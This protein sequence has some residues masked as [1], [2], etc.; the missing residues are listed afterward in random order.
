[1]RRVII[2]TMV[3]IL[4]F[5]CGVV[6]LNWYL[7]SDAGDTTVKMD[8]ATLPVIYTSVAGEK[9]NTMHGYIS[10]IDMSLLRDSVTPVEQDETVNVVIDPADYEVSK[11]RYEVRSAD[12]SSLVEDG[13]VD[14][15]KE[16]ENGEL[17]ASIKVRMQLKMGQ[18]Y[19]L[20]LVLEGAGSV[21]IS[22]YTRIICNE[23]MHAKE[24][25]AF[26]KE[27]NDAIF[28][29]KKAE[30]IRKYLECDA[31]KINNDLG[32]VNITSS[33]EAITFAEMKP[34]KCAEPVPMITDI[35][36]DV[37]CTSLH[38]LISAESS[39]GATEYYEVTENYKVRYTA[40][41]MYLLSYDRTMNSLYDVAFTNTSANSLKLGI[42]DTLDI[43]YSIS[44]DCKMAAFVKARQL[45]LYDYQSSQVI[46]VFKFLEDD[47]E[48]VDVRS[49]YNQHDIRLLSVDKNGD[50]AFA[51]Y[52]YMNRGRY[53]GQNGILFYQYKREQNQLEQVAFI[54]SSQPFGILKEDMKQAVYM[55]NNQKIYLALSGTFYS[56]NTKTDEVN[57]IAK[58]INTDT[59]MS[60]QDGHLVGMQECADTAQN[61]KITVMNLEDG[62]QQQVVAKGKE[63]I[64][65]L[66]FVENDLVYGRIKKNKIVA[67][68]A[69]NVQYPMYKIE[70]VNK[71]GNI[72]KSYKTSAANTYIMSATMNKNVVELKLG[73][74][75]GES[76]VEKGS[77]YIMSKSNNEETTVTLDYEYNSVRYKELYMIF[78]NY[79]YVTTQPQWNMANEV[80]IDDNRMIAI[81]GEENGVV[82]YFVYANG[83]AVDSY[84]NVAQAVRMANEQDGVVVNSKQKTVWE[85]SGLKDYATIGEDVPVVKV[86][87]EKDSILACVCSILQFKGKDIALS[88]IQGTDPEELLTKYLNKEGINLTG[89]TLDEVMYYICQGK[90][91]IAQNSQGRY[92]L[93]TSFNMSLL[94]Y[95]DPVTGEVKRESFS[96]M[97]QEFEKAGNVFYSY[98]D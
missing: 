90:P 69:T 61:Q 19:I 28:S 35:T 50:L 53:E 33:F 94:K 51:V 9:V 20:K 88:Q 66:G 84:N 21:D 97:R 32:N 16:T 31:N 70:I 77:D 58:D 4:V 11:L 39:G 73:K 13:D 81:E 65:L 96:A 67:K 36:E 68:D 22:Y 93:L 63:V 23:T 40:D 2:R 6:G 38:Y 25:I 52:G 54:P 60:S 57:V 49:S 98:L 59:V 76:F 78:P 83:K 37:A 44:E 15:W 74:K 86:I 80:L 71:E 72:A 27:F 30:N 29:K 87:K 79:I 8:H 55:T 10:D 47:M 17:S 34:Q 42:S 64:R 85:N 95:T 5:L 56:V 43:N 26:V 41:R 12:G 89:C 18:D 91:V 48:Q 75:E 62:S 82:K 1:M 92:V 7:S 14:K 46:R 45:F 3:F 24:Q